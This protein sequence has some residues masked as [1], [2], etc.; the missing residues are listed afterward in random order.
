VNTRGGDERARTFSVT[1]SSSQAADMEG[2]PGKGWIIRAAPVV[3]IVVVVAVGSGLTPGA[4][5]GI[6]HTIIPL[7]LPGSSSDMFCWSRA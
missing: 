4:L 7:A 6:Y 1:N 5:L 2:C 3:V